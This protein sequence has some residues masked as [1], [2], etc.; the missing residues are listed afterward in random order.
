MH[1]PDPREQRARV[2]EAIAGAL[3]LR[4]QDGEEA[5]E[6]WEVLHIPGDT[7]L[8]VN[9]PERGQY[10]DIKTRVHIKLSIPW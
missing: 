10:G 5:Y 6:G 8:T 1:K 7:C 9:L 2:A 3:E 4:I